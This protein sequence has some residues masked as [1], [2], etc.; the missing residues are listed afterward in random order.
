[1]QVQLVMDAFKAFLP[2]LS[3]AP[4]NYT[5]PSGA[6]LTSAQVFDETP[7]L[8]YTG[9]YPFILIVPRQITDSPQ[10]E[11][12]AIWAQGTYRL[13]FCDLIAGVD[14]NGQPMGDAA[15]IRHA[16]L[17][18][19]ALSQALRASPQARSLNGAVRS[20][21]WGQGLVFDGTSG[22][23]IFDPQQLPVIG[24]PIDIDVAEKPASE[25]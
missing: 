13:L 19:S 23:F 21:G 5:L 9:D 8:P 14:E 6:A 7:P 4:T 1:M 25:P 10:G 15:V 24:I 12:G 20:A 18:A 16:S 3:N 11:A 17:F 2:T 22:V